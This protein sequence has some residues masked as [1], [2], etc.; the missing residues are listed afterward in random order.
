MA[1]AVGTFTVQATFTGLSGVNSAPLTTTDTHVQRNSVDVLT[2]SLDPQG[3]GSLYCGA[4]VLDLAVGDTIDF[5]VGYGN[6]SYNSDTTGVD[7]FICP[8]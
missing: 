8:N 6:G 1:S 4:A 5:A 2:G 3:A 7:A